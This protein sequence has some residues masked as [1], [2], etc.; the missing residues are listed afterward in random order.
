[1]N[2]QFSPASN[3]QRWVRDRQAAIRNRRGN[4]IHF[5][6]IDRIENVMIDAPYDHNDSGAFS[7]S[8]R[9]FWYCESVDASFNSMND[10]YNWVMSF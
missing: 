3:Q 8:S 7:S 10:A 2:T 4:W 1:M 5:N 6:R 9:T